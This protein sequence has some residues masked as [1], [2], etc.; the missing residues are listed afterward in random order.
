M[1]RKG[2][3]SLGV[4]GLEHCKHE[5]LLAYILILHV[6]CQHKGTFQHA[7]QI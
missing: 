6:G 1:G 4:R 5:M 3:A 7:V 2:L